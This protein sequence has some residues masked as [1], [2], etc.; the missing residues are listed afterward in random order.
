MYE[1]NLKLPRAQNLNKAKEAFV[2]NMPNRTLEHTK[3]PPKSKIN[4][5]EDVNSE[6]CLIQQ[7]SDPH[8]DLHDNLVQAWPY[9]Q[10]YVYVGIESESTRWKVWDENTVKCIE[11]RIKY[12]LEFDGNDVKI[13]RISKLLGKPCTNEFIWRLDIT[14]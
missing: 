2:K 9:N 14:C 5:Y 1:R 7:T 10:R 8:F 4:I 6:M 11:D 3:W 12:D 13:L